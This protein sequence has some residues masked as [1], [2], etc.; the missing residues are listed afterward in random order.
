MPHTDMCETDEVK[1]PSGGLVAGGATDTSSARQC[2]FG[3]YRQRF[4]DTRS[5]SCLLR[6]V[7]KRELL[8]GIRRSSSMERLPG[9][10][11]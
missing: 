6:E 8:R 10:R 2:G 7:S 4:T 3:L 5:W 11:G 1:V 9:N